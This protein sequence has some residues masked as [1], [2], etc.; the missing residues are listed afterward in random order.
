M[1]ALMEL[2]DVSKLRYYC[3]NILCFQGRFHFTQGQMDKAIE[4]YTASYKSQ[5]EWPQF[6][7]LCYWDIAISHQL[8]LNYWEA[9]KFSKLLYQESHWSKCFYAYMQ[10]ANMCMVKD[11]LSQDQ[12]KEQEVS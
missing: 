9:Y 6:H 7:H 2:N 1:F 8:N 5:N 12:K 10:A 4:F 3:P 11:E